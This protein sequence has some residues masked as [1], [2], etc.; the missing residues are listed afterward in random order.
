MPSKE[1]GTRKRVPCFQQYFVFLREKKLH[2]VNVIAE[3]VE[4][5]RTHERVICAGNL[6]G[7]V[8][9]IDAPSVTVGESKTKPI[10]SGISHSASRHA[11]MI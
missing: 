7:G 11:E 6:F 10:S 5:G 8:I 2:R 3:I 1:L 4:L 9:M